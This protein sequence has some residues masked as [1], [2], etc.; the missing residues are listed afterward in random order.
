MQV[1]ALDAIH[2]KALLQ[3][4]TKLDLEYPTESNDKNHIHTAENQ[5]PRATL[6]AQSL[7]QAQ[8]EKFF[9]IKE[10]A[11]QYY[12]VLQ[13]IWLACFSIHLL[14]PLPKKKS[15]AAI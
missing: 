11:A 7:Q 12:K 14:L 13:N 3:V 8:L 4:Y 2:D 15:I 9:Q 1:Y 6:A 10:P 5:K